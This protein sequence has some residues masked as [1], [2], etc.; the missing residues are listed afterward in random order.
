MALYNFINSLN[1][2]DSLIGTNNPQEDVL[3]YIP[4]FEEAAK[5]NATQVCATIM[6]IKLNAQMDLLPSEDCKYLHAF[7]SEVTQICRGNDCCR[8]I[9]IMPDYVF[10]VYS[11]PQ[12][13][14]VD[15]VIDD[16]ARINSLSM[17]VNKKSKDKFSLSVTIGID[18]GQVVM[19]P[20][21]GA[22]E[23]TT[24]T[25]YG[26][27]IQEVKKMTEESSHEYIYITQVIWNN[28]RTENQRLFKKTS[29]MED[30]YAGSIINVT[31]NNWV[32]T[33]E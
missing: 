28:I 17:V 3:P 8:D 13:V 5:N 32:K 25:W 9:V 2:I 7:I 30:Y 19:M 27:A 1:R 23:T 29:I 11:T 14:N 31:M 4:T 24:F 15:A 20:V 16:S 6:C 12:K 33:A 26:P 21:S 22:N 10:V 18:Y